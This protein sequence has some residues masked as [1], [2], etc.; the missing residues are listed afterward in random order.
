MGRVAGKVTDES[1]KGIEG[2]TVRGTI[3][4]GGSPVDDQ[5]QLEG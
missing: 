5:V 2:V 3:A 4:A 1:G